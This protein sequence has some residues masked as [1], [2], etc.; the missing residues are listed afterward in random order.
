MYCLHPVCVNWFEN[1]MVVVLSLLVGTRSS[2]TFLIRALLTWPLVTNSCFSF[3]ETPC[4]HQHDMNF[5]RNSLASSSLRRSQRPRTQSREW[6]EHDNLRARLETF[7]K[8]WQQL[9][10]ALNQPGVSPTSSLA[11][12]DWSVAHQFLLEMKFL[13]IK[14]LEWEKHCYRM[15]PSK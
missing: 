1:T 2:N 3:K 10:E 6:Q 13:L 9:E 5:I 11:C 12:W 15:K 7:R 4:N 14:S 8:H